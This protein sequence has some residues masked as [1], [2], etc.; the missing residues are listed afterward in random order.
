MKLTR[1]IIFI[2]LVLKHIILMN[3]VT[4]MKQISMKKLKIK[5]CCT[6]IR[7][8][9]QF[10]V[11]QLKR[12]AATILHC[13]ITLQQGTIFKINPNLQR[14]YVLFASSQRKLCNS[15]IQSFV[16]FS[17]KHKQRCQKS[18]SHDFR[19]CVCVCGGC[20]F[21]C[22]CGCVRVCVSKGL[23]NNIQKNYCY[24]RDVSLKLN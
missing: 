24:V 1:I 7:C 13:N 10:L 6:L 9:E 18:V 15:K 20:G 16:K 21:W 8:L 11:L 4:L 19:K 14:K 12:V 17:Q 22:G 23:L 3:I 5:F 2:H